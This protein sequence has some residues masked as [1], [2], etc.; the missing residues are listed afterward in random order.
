MSDLLHLRPYFESGA[1]EEGIL[2]AG[3]D[4]VAG[5][6]GDD[7]CELHFRL[8]AEAVER[9]LLARAHLS[10][11][12]DPDGRLYIQPLG[13]S[14]EAIHAAVEAG[15]LPSR[16]LRSLVEASLAPEELR[17][18]DAPLESLASL[19]SQLVEALAMVDRAIS[20]LNKR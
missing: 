20:V 11:E 16:D 9:V 3:A 6:R 14:E 1:D 5:L 2:S 12:L 10:V 17:M 15:Y 8:R 18:E 19:R 13:L 4:Y 7:G